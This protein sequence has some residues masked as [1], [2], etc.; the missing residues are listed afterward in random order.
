MLRPANDL[1][2][3]VHESQ[4]ELVRIDRAADPSAE[5]LVLSMGCVGEDRQQVLVAP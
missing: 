2:V 4:V 5:V 1:E 3:G